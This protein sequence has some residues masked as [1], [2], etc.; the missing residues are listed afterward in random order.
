MAITTPVN[1]G[2]V[3]SSIFIQLGS[4]L[5]RASIVA[6][7]E[8][9]NVYSGDDDTNPPLIYH[10]TNFLMDNVSVYSVGSMKMVASDP[11]VYHPSPFTFP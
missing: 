10:P 1:K 4:S 7:D 2:I 8:T 9:V 3:N 6:G 5:H 11:C